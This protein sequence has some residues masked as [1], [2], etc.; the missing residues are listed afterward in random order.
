MS[1]GT[2]RD[3]N[4]TAI[5]LSQIIIY[6]GLITVRTGCIHSHIA[7]VTLVGC[8]PFTS[9][10]GPLRVRCDGTVASIEIQGQALSDQGCTLW[11]E[12]TQT[13][14][15]KQHIQTQFIGFVAATPELRPDHSIPQ[16][17]GR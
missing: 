16:D 17:H 7:L 5:S 3:L 14:H 4:L 12:S 13:P 11:L 8:H 6:E 15:Q 10:N 9:G 2:L 1:I